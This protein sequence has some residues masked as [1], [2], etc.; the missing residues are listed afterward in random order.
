MRLRS[1]VEA[2][3]RRQSPTGEC[4][5]NGGSPT[6]LCCRDPS[7]PTPPPR[8]CERCGRPVPRIVVRVNRTPLPVAPACREYTKLR[9]F[10]ENEPAPTAAWEDSHLQQAQSGQ[11]T[12]R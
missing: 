8:R 9:D 7:V 11:G 3:E 1:R 6:I 10:Y 5:C 2:I 4:G 12:H